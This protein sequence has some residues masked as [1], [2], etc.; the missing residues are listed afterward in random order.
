VTQ[1]DLTLL[2]PCSLMNVRRLWAI[3]F[4]TRRESA[5]KFPVLFPVTPFKQ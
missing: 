2:I 3:D 5:D 4:G 1:S